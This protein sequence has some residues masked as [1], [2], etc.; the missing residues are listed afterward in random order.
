MMTNDQSSRS[1]LTG[2][3]DGPPGCIVNVTSVQSSASDGEGENVVTSYT[4]HNSQQGGPYE[5][6]ING[7]NSPTYE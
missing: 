3:Y 6:S 1:R 2:C 5:S 7:T 4:M